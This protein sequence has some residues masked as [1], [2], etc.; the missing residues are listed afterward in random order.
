MLDGYDF[1]SEYQRKMKRKECNLV[2]IDDLHKD[3]FFADVILNSGGGCISKNF[4][5]TEPCTKI[6]L[7]VDTQLSEPS[8][9]WEKYRGAV[10]A[11]TL[12]AAAMISGGSTTDVTIVN[13]V[14]LFGSFGLTLIDI[15]QFKL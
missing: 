6:F 2:C 7:G 8:L 10:I 14:G 4:Y 9:N 3:H 1:G 15:I 5:S 11:T 13:V 12:G